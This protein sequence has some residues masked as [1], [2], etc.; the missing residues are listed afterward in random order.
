MRKKGFYHYKLFKKDMTYILG[1]RCINGVVLVGDT[2]VTT[3]DGF[4]YS[5]KIAIPFGNVVMASSGIGGLYKEFQNR[6]IIAVKLIEQQREKTGY[7]ITTD[8]D[9]SVLVTR[10]IRDMIRE[11]GDDDYV[12]KNNL[13]IICAT[14]IGSPLNQYY[15][16]AQLSTYHP[17]GFPEPVNK[18]E[19][20]GHGKPYGE[21]FLKNLYRKEMTMK[22]GTKLGLFIIQFIKDMHLDESVGYDDEFLPQVVYIPD[23][24]IPEN[25]DPNDEIKV[26]KVYEGYPIGELS[27]E[28]VKHFMNEIGSKV[29]DFNNLFREG[30]FKL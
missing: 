23:I 11:Y 19:A 13:R 12:L 10:V 14:R 24:Q 6:I 18:Y 8:E 27:R 26:K 17:Y 20:I 1:A 9:F 2:K 5:K 7:Y 16:L 29:A 22:E 21:L 25:Y 4:A 30:K 3:E 15:P 28:D